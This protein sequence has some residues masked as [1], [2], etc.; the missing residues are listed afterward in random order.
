MKTPMPTRALLAPHAPLHFPLELK[1][2]CAAKAASQKMAIKKSTV[3]R[4]YGFA[5][6]RVRGNRGV[7]VRNIMVG[8]DRKHWLTLV[9]AI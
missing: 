7:M 4:A 5:N 8:I 2:A 6:F 1:L 3:A 9:F